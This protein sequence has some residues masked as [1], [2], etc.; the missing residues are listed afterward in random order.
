MLTCLDARQFRKLLSRSRA[1][2]AL[3]SAQGPSPLTRSVGDRMRWT[4]RGTPRVPWD[5]VGIFDG[6]S[7]FRLDKDGRIYEHQA[8]TC[9]QRAAL[10][11]PRSAASC[12]NSRRSR[13]LGER[14]TEQGSQQLSR[15]T[16]RLLLAR[17]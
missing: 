1:E 4:V 16:R 5:A 15:T 11:D 14:F 13:W 8:R 3:R 6:V 12:C 17:L 9:A 2:C 10:L 7:T